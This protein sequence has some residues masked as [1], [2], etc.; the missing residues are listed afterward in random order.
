M[1]LRLNAGAYFH[2]WN[3]ERIVWTKRDLLFIYSKIY[4]LIFCLIIG[5]NSQTAFLS[6]RESL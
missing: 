2:R 5:T 4:Y 1:M 3:D 6:Q